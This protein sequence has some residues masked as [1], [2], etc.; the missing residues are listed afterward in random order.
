MGRVRH[1]IFS[2]GGEVKCGYWPK[3]GINIT[4]RCVNSYS[5]TA[6][7]AKSVTHVLFWWCVYQAQ[8]HGGD[9][10][11]RPVAWPTGNV[12]FSVRGYK[13]PSE[14]SEPS[15]TPGCFRRK[16]GLLLMY[17][18]LYSIKLP[19]ALDCTLPS[20][21]WSTLLIALDCTLPGCVT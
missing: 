18:M 2:N 21:L 3:T 19:N 1:P 8:S 11:T 20:T 15:G 10:V 14:P 12:K 13:V 9:D 5:V 17:I 6:A 4:R 16:L 7:P